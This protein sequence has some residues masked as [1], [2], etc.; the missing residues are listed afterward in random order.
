MRR[1]IIASLMLASGL[2]VGSADAQTFPSKQ[3][4]LVVPFA[5]GGPTDTLGR[6]LA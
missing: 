4:T 1:K 2:T 3:I 6:V 5:A